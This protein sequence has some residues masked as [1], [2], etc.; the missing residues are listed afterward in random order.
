[1]NKPLREIMLNNHD[2]TYLSEK[3]NLL[4]GNK[5]IIIPNGRLRIGSPNRNVMRKLF[6]KR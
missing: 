4:Y 5:E 2:L 3:V 6:N 1:V